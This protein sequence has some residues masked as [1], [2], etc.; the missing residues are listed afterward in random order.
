MATPGGEKVYAIRYKNVFVSN[1]L[2][3]RTLKG[4]HKAKRMLSRYM[5][6]LEVVRIQTLGRVLP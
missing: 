6:G 4:A 1:K 3:F 5:D 2:V